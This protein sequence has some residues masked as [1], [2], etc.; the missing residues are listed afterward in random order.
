MLLI[1]DNSGEKPEII[2]EQHLNE[3]EGLE[4]KILDDAARR[5]DEVDSLA[6]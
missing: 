2:Y 6:R 3:A 4:Q 5:M 1:K